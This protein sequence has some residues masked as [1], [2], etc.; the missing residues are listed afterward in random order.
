M[1]IKKILFYLLAGLLGGCL[2][3]TSLH[4]FYT[5]EN[6]T[7]EEGILG[8]WVEDPNNPE[9]TWE[10]TR[11]VN[12]KDSNEIAY[13]LIFTDE[14]GKKG[15]FIAHLLKLDVKLFMDAYPSEIPWEPKD[16]NN[17]EWPY[18]T[19]F[20]IPTHTVLKIDSTKPVL[21]IRMTNEEKMKE[22]LKENPT[23]IQHTFVENRLVLT[24]STKELQAFILKY[25][26]DERVFP[27]ETIL[28]RIK[29]ATK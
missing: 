7:F 13:K 28:T 6:L 29:T 4:Q 1:K 20:L 14:E 10:F 2:P 27:N 16:P 5:P 18:N 24:A 22:L 8:K 25:T 9:T 11:F 15:S 21:K 19:L 17:I 12:P 23:A 26:D 3:I